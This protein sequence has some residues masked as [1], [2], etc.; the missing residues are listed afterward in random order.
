[1]TPSGHVVDYLLSFTT[2]IPNSD[3]NGI[4]LDAAS[5]I[6]DFHTKKLLSI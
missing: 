4:I 5:L 3:R 2:F 1:M 6:N